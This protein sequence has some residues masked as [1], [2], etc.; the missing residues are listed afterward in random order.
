[1]ILMA[2]VIRLDGDLA[3][4][5]AQLVTSVSNE[6]PSQAVLSQVEGPSQGAAAAEF[7]GHL[8]MRAEELATR[9]G[10]VQEY[11]R[12]NAEALNAAVTTL[13]ERDEL[14]AAAAD[15]TASLI[16]T[17]V[18]PAANTPPSGGAA[19]VRSALGVTQ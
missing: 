11:V 1:M 16:E 4:Y 13:R 6:L 3:N 18:A 19:G 14:S 9:V 7:I 10:L 12:L 17:A 8:R 5:N 2:N 15:Q